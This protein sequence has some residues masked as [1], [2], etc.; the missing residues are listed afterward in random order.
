[1]GRSIALALY[2]LT[3]RGG[4]VPPAPSRPARPDGA[5]IWLHL[6]RDATPR[7]LGQ[8]AQKLV[9]ERPELSLLI[10]RDG[11][12]LPDADNFPKGA[13][14]DL[15]PPDNQTAIHAFLDHWRP[16]LCVLAGGSLPPVLICETDRRNIPL[17]LVN[18]RMT[19][20]GERAWRW[21]RGMVASLLSRFRRIM[22]QDPDSAARLR[23]LGGRLAQIDVAGRIEETTEPLTCSETERSS[24]A[25]LLMARPIWL[26]AGCTEAEEDAVIAAHAHAMRLAHRMLLIVAPA[27]P[28]RAGPLAERLRQVGWMIAERSREEEPDPEVQAFV[29]DGEEE[30]GL[31]YRLAPVTFMGGTLIE[32]GPSRNPFEPAALGSAILHGPYP[33]PYPDA[34]A[35]LTEARAA[36][37]VDSGA[38]LAEAV[39]EMIAADKAA[40]LAHNAWA[41]SSGGAEVAERVAQAVFE[42]LDATARKV[43]M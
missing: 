40:I 30:L 3:A 18:I 15:C 28:A 17:M 13:I 9:R 11:D 29:A 35:R 32:G 23:R 20:A 41:A 12:A 10:T 42:A 33:G 22:A 36:R 14:T 39:G 21:R 31:W 2:L 26:V 19:Q 8:L 16:D 27:D 37:R 7:R 34:Y 5:L 25:E 43:A 24:L 4:T 6:G 1:M 38:T